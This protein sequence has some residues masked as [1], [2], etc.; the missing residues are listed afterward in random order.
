[1]KKS[2]I[3][4]LLM[5]MYLLPLWSQTILDR[6]SSNKPIWLN[7]PPKGKAYLYYTGVGTSEKSLEIAQKSAMANVI[8]LISLEGTTTIQVSSTFAKEEE[9]DLKLTGTENYSFRENFI[10]VIR[11]DGE[12][13][14]I[15][16]LQKEEE[17][18]QKVADNGIIYYQYWVLMRTLKPNY[19]GPAKIR[20]GY[21]MAPV[22]RSAILPGWGQLYKKEKAKGIIVL[23]ATA[24]AVAGIII[25]QTMYQSNIYNA[26]GTHDINLINAYLT[27]ANTWQ[28]TRNI[29]SVAAGAIYIY[30]LVDAMTAKGAKRYAWQAPRP[31]EFSP[32]MDDRSVGVSVC[33]NF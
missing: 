1:M 23:S 27:D 20:E 24:V 30:N 22:W 21:G 4:T 28:S 18:W 10:E 32:V 6:S 8:S 13:L 31:V 3:S 2:I 9:R 29:F 26:E 33:I 11:S 25:S 14:T 17:Y 16:G 7:E 19:T 12:K 5:L 15:R